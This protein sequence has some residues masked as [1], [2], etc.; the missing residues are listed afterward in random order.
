MS[1]D[2]SSKVVVPL[3]IASMEASFANTFLSDLV[4]KPRPVVGNFKVV[5]NPK[6]SKIPLSA[7]AKR[8]VWQLISPGK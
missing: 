7:V 5:G 1:F 6:S 4:N 2:I 8:C 3:L